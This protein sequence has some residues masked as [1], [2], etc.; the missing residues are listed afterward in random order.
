MRMNLRIGFVVVTALSPLLGACASSGGGSGGA[1]GQASEPEQAQPAAPSVDQLPKGTEPSDNIYT[2]SAEL[3]LNRARQNT[4]IEEKRQR[5]QEALDAAIQGIQL[6]P[7]NPKPYFLAGRAYLGMGD[8]MGADSML[9]R[10]ETIYPRYR[11]EETRVLRESQWVQQ[12]NQGISRL[13]QGDTEAAI[14]FFQRANTIYKGRPVSQLNLAQAYAQLDQTEKAIQAYR[15]ALGVIRSDL[16]GQQPEDRQ[17]QWKENEEIAAFNLAQL[18]A[19]AGRNEEAA[20]AYRDF[21][22]ENPDNVTAMSNLA[23]VLNNMQMRDSAMVIYDSLLERTDLS[24]QEY[25]NAGIGLYQAERYERAAEAFDRAA[26][27]NPANRDAVYN[28]AQTLFLSEQFDRLVP[29]AERLVEELDPYNPNAYKLY[30][31]ALVQTG[32]EN[33][34]LEYQNRMENLPFEVSGTHLQ[35]IGGGGGV[36]TGEITNKTLEAGE[37][38]SLTFTWVDGDGM[39]LGTTDV[40]LEAPPKGETVGFRTEIEA[41]EVA[42]GFR[43]ASSSSM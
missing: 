21:L 33:R 3:Y 14:E 42:R 26:E 6:E 11:P 32:Q 24:A 30:V 23:L 37:P 9:T 20:Q 35:P 17:E 8:V 12:Y 19:Q 25:F 40:N 2:R 41:E 16:F 5:F 39:E 34:A 38:I 28:L 13:Q 10:A 27:L 4:I 43:Y 36:V 1:T 18:L 15:D 7:G 31:N 29:V 22:E